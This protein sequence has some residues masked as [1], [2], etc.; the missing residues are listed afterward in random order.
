MKAW[1]L[2]SSIFV[3]FYTCNAQCPSGFTRM[4]SNLN[5]CYKYVHAVGVQADV[6]FGVCRNLGADVIS[7]QSA[8]ENNELNGKS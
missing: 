4:E 2:Y 1:V 8:A 3:L 7:I 6:A 5:K